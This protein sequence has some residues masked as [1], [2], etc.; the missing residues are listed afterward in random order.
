MKQDRKM[1]KKLKSEVGSIENLQSLINISHTQAWR[2]FNGHSKLTKKNEAI[3]RSN[4][5]KFKLKRWHAESL[6]KEWLEKVKSKID[7]FVVTST[8]INSDSVIA[9]VSVI[10]DD[11]SKKCIKEASSLLEQVNDY[12]LRDAILS[13]YFDVL[14]SNEVLT[15]EFKIEDK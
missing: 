5:Q 13:V 10:E 4:L 8:S 14:E 11:E 3:L 2:I 12:S 7:G 9:R 1:D 6:A 15:K